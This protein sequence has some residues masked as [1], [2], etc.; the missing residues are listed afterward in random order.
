MTIGHWALTRNVYFV[1][2]LHSRVTKSQMERMTVSGLDTEGLYKVG[3]FPRR[4]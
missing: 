3:W 1:H 4:C 2:F